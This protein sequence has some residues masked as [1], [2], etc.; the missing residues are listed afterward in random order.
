MT[1]MAASM[2]YM[3]VGMQLLMSTPMA[4]SVLPAI[5]EMGRS[6]RRRRLALREKRRRQSA[7][8]AGV[9]ENAGGCGG[10]ARNTVLSH[11]HRRHAGAYRLAAL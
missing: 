10:G 9:D 3:F 2:G 6:S 11:R 8:L 7:V 4:P 5:A 1:V